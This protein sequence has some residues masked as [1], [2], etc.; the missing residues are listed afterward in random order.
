M[1]HTSLVALLEDVVVHHDVVPPKLHLV[2]H[3]R[4][5]APNLEKM[6]F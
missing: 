2:L 6:Q 5:Q 1:Q 3:V 4:K